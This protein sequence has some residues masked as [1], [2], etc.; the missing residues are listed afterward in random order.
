MCFR[1][2]QLDQAVKFEIAIGQNAPHGSVATCPT[3]CYNKLK[4]ST[5]NEIRPTSRVIGELGM[6]E[7]V[8]AN[9][10]KCRKDTG[11]VFLG[12]FLFE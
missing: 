5:R 9:L 7:L 12:R 6:L 3:H 10:S 2:R 11:L 8:Q 1:N 4:A